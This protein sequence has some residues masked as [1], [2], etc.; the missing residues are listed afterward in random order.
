MKMK[1]ASTTISKALSNKKTQELLKL[2][3]FITLCDAPYTHSESDIQ[4]SNLFSFVRNKCIPDLHQ[5][6][7]NTNGACNYHVKVC[8][9]ETKTEQR[10]MKAP[11][12]C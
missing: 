1:R 8:N 4:K 3:N 6:C 2:T 10:N 9:R 5:H 12:K 7:I 11:L